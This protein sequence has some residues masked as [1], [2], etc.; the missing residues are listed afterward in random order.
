M[1]YPPQP[2]QPYGQQP[3]PYGQGG[4]PSPGGFQ[5]QYP[6]RP[7]PAQQPQYPQQAQYPQQQPY[8]GQYPGQQYPGYSQGFGGPPAPPKKSRK[9]LWAGISAVVVLLVAFG[10]TG[11]LAP[12]FLLGKDSSDTADGA[13]Q[14]LVNALNTKDKSALT[15]LKCG[16]ASTTVG[17]A[18][19]EIS[20]VSKVALHGPV[21]RVSATE[22][23]ADLDVTTSS[24]P[25]PYLSTFD[26]EGGKWCWKDI[27]HG[28]SDDSDSEPSGSPA[29]I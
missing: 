19:D 20:K 9:G 8:P 6:S 23:T 25:S 2:G 1:T 15:A 18:I 29:T 5:Q 10:V 21:K 3:D 16:D 28:S 12:G 13:A 4:H 22:Y 17:Q 26:K 7:Y 11:F 27:D 14:S 24:K